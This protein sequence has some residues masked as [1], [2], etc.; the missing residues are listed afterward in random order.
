MVEQV[1]EIQTAAAQMNAEAVEKN[2]E[3][4][5]VGEMNF[6]GTIGDLQKK[7]PEIYQKLVLQQIAF[8]IVRDCQRSS[9]HFVEEMKKHRDG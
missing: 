6:D 5:P 7:H 9:E 2:L 4:K 3:N 8:Q 1:M